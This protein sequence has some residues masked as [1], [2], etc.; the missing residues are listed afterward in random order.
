MSFIVIWFTGSE[1]FLQIVTTS[2]CISFLQIKGRQIRVDHIMDYKVPKEDE[3]IDE[4][5]M[6]IREKGVAPQVMN[7]YEEDKVEVVNVEE[8][9]DEIII[10]DSDDHAK[11]SE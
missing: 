10:S 1:Y 7:E 6:K 3:E 5:T 9:V 2:T 4:L 11:G 8:E